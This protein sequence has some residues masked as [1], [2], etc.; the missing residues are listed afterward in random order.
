MNNPQYNYPYPYPYPYFQHP[1]PTPST[2]TGP[3]PDPRSAAQHSSP[4]SPGPAVSPAMGQGVGAAPS[5]PFQ[6]SH[7]SHTLPGQAAGQHEASFF[8][9]R[10][11]RFLRGLLIGATATYILT[12]E[13]VQR[14][15]I[16]GMVRVWSTLQG[17]LEELKE[18]FQD[19]EAELRSA[20]DEEDA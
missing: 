16:K 1:A 18:R 14:S 4:A 13:K 7:P 11:E 10:N 17:G 19:A 3:S 6:A 9:F 2:Q 12:N 8:N 15:T 5:Y 20:D